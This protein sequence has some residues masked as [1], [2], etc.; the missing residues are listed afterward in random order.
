MA[1]WS[2]SKI[3]AYRSAYLNFT[4]HVRINSKEIGEC[5]LG[6]TRYDA[7][8]IMLNGIFNGL[9]EDIHDFTI[10]KS[11]QLGISTESRAFTLF[12]AGMHTGL[13]GYFVTYESKSLA[14][15][16]L[17]LRQMTE[18]LPSKL[19]FP[20]VVWNR[21][22]GLIQH[23]AG[24][25]SVIMFAAAG[26]KESNRSGK[27]GVGSGINF[28]HATELSL[29]VSE[30]QLEAFI[31]GLAENFENRLYIWESTGRGFDNVFPQLWSNAKADDTRKRTIFLGWWSKETQRIE[32]SDP[33]YDKY[34][35]PFLTGREAERIKSVKDLYGYDILPEQLAWYRRKM[36][37]AL[38]SLSSDSSALDEDPL[39]TQEQPWT[40]VEMFLETGASF[41]SAERLNQQQRDNVSRPTS[42][43]EYEFGPEFTDTKISPARSV[44]TI[45]LKVWEEPVS[46]DGVYIISGDPAG[47][48]SEKGDRS[49][50]QV[51]RAYA[52]GVD[53]VAEF[54]SKMVG[55]QHFAWVIATLLGQYL[56]QGNEIYFIL[57]ING[58]GEAVLI[59]LKNLK[60]LV[61]QGYLR[62]EAEDR[63][64]ANI[65]R[66]VKQF[67]WSRAD[68]L[69][70]STQ[71][72]HFKTNSSTKK[73][74]MERFRDFAHSGALRLRSHALVSEMRT[75]TVD[76]DAVSASAGKNDDRVIGEALGV[77][78]WEDRIR[79]RMSQQRRTR[80]TE[81]SKATLSLIDMHEMFS[82]YQ[83]GSFFGAKQGLRRA[84]S[85]AA[86]R[87]KW[88]G[89]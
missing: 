67:Y 61:E 11:R 32:R 28:V 45:Q 81:E 54:A 15:A 53:Q 80:A 33:A 55:T 46:R 47:G 87:N 84:A 77:R 41:F 12:W 73:P 57:E 39:K 63:G 69:R 65:F 76:G 44:R 59:E 83:M 29:W 17:E 36:D 3:A 1:G 89:R 5:A 2:S 10:G 85:V 88:R 49:C 34:G 27:L 72:I 60:K 6:E 43:W 52:D 66:K 62:D 4:S 13:K 75:V 50:V 26:T 79:N 40:E 51:N 70:P 64:F 42:V 58:P 19:G 35:S 56:A 21:D 38:S 71:T 23:G 31:N 22:R 74:L 82:Q 25:E 18:S 48:S 68:A 37:P 8:K 16:Q 78:M 20:K 24:K 9:G 86:A 14:E 30:Q 7:Q